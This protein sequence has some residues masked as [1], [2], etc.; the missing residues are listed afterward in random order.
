MA[1]L[2]APERVLPTLNADGTRRR[3]RPKLYRGRIHS[4]RRIVAA[5]LLA[6]FVALPF[7]RLNEKPL[8]LLD[9]QAREFTLFG[10]TFLPT[11]GVLLMLLMLTI[12]VAVIWIT[13]LVG[14][15]WCGWACPQTVYLEFLFRP[16]ERLIEGD[17]AQQI[18]L[19]RNSLSL[20]RV[21]KWLVFAL[22][23]AFVGNVFLA[24]FVGTEALIHWMTRPP[25]EHPAGFV[26]M[27]ATAGL[28]FF[29]FAYFREQMCTVVCPYA[30]LQSVL[31]DK[32]SL[33][34]GYD[35]NRG[36]PRQKG[37]P[38][39]GFGDCI[40]CTAC[41]VACPTG[42]DIREGLQLECVACGQCV[43]ACNSVMSRIKKPLGLIRYGS[44]ESFEN[45]SEK[46]RIF[47][48]R[49]V[50]YPVLLAALLGALL[51]VGSR[52]ASADV[53]VLRGIG[54]P[55]VE[56]P[57]GVSNQI[58]IKIENHGESAASYAIELLDAP[59]ARLIAPENPLLVPRHS[60]RSTSVF[61]VLPRDA[62]PSGVR[63]VRF[64]VS[65]G[66]FSI[67]VPYKLLGPDS[68]AA[69][70]HGGAS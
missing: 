8:I 19:D 61:V 24:Y 48:P 35:G 69:V 50:I 1:V 34:I 55:F 2:P 65:G 67:E 9:L 59:G 41:V 45:R 44:Q 31:L 47:R 21:V 10:R 39:P 15:A 46:P 64:K 4:A 12:F 60:R 3:V 14:R 49:V 25:S 57:D 38:K 32:R 63:P 37:K 62:F 43:D 22:L 66:G 30:R 20:R 17:R 29:D 5:S 52:R 42:I 56:Q 40:D 18:R 70:H 26:V 58:R 36:E 68:R 51:F 28:M 53:T 54:A 11:E 33:I 13:A 6:L 23:S 7:F 16:I 27:A